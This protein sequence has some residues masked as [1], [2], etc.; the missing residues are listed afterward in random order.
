[1]SKV[2]NGAKKFVK[3]ED[4]S[5]APNSDGTCPTGYQLN[6]DKTR[7]VVM[8]SVNITIIPKNATEKSLIIRHLEAH[9]TA[10]TVVKGQIKTS[11]MKEELSK[12]KKIYEDEGV[13]GTLGGEPGPEGGVTPGEEGALAA[14][15]PVDGQCPEG[16]VLSADGKK[17]VVAPEP[18]VSTGEPS[19]VPFEITHESKNFIVDGPLN[20]KLK[21]GQV[22]QFENLEEIEIC[23][24]KTE[25]VQIGQ[26]GQVIVLK[27]E[28][29]CREFLNHV[30]FKDDV[31]VESRDLTIA[32]TLMTDLTPIQIAEKILEAGRKKGSLAELKKSDRV[33]VSAIRNV[34]RSRSVE[35]KVEIIR[36]NP[37]KVAVK[38]VEHIGVE[39]K[40]A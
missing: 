5:V 32:Q 28:S 9:D 40:K 38:R 39:V 18:A 33:T 29:V 16:F 24:S 37:A 35:N 27:S 36:N 19:A 34:K 14:T 13:A 26:S 17:C 31:Q 22:I 30:Y 8:E 4:D 12:F 2:L 3:E 21:N 11:M 7:C 20:V 15:M 23:K 10:Y 6:S 25:D 1:M